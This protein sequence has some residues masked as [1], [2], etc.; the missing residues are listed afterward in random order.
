MRYIRSVCK[1]NFLRWKT[2]LRVIMLLVVLAALQIMYA[3]P[4]IQNAA[5]FGYPLQI[6][7]TYIAAFSGGPASFLVSIIVVFILADVPVR[8]KGFDLALTRGSFR[9]WLA[10]QWLY[11]IIC[12]FVLCTFM[13]VF[14]IL[15][16]IPSAYLPNEWSTATMISSSTGKASF[17]SGQLFSIIP[18]YI[19]AN[20]LPVSAMLSTFL[21]QFLLFCFY[22]T[23]AVF[24]N[25]R[26]NHVV[27]PMVLILLNAIHWLMRMF[28]PGDDVFIVLS[29][30]SPLYHG[31][32]SE[33]QFYSITEGGMANATVSGLMLL[34]FSIVFAIASHFFIRK[35]D[36]S[37][38]TGGDFDE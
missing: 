37:N 21:L 8:Y 5:G 22:G 1:L 17:G 4:Y 20:D 3:L 13:L 35:S 33:H 9:K 6:F 10:G 25:L 29:W 14:N 30:L 31:T 38:F 19:V 2:S 34:I 27:A 23:L 18:K 12:A 11:I 32:Y 28:V 15:I 36:V 7:E 24:I 26:S 16:S